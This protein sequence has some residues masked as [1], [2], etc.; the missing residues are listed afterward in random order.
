MRGY[1]RCRGF[2][3]EAFD[4][5]YDLARPGNPSTLSSHAHLRQTEGTSAFLNRLMK[6]EAEAVWCGNEKDL[7]LLPVSL[8][9]SP[10]PDADAIRLD[11]LFRT[12][13]VRNQNCRAILRSITTVYGKADLYAVPLEYHGGMWVSTTLHFLEPKS[14]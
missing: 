6:V 10:I 7:K 5:V 4:R 8:I 1:V 12:A 2:T 13:N 9:D 3:A 11:L 14:P